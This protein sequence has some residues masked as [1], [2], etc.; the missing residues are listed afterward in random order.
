[1]A[2]PGKCPHCNGTTFC[3]GFLHR[4]T[5]LTQPAC[6][7]CLV[8]SGLPA[9]GN[10]HRVICSV[11]GGTGAFNPGGRA[12]RRSSGSRLLMLSPILLAALVASFLSVLGYYEKVKR[13]EEEQKEVERFKKEVKGP[14]GETSV[15][16]LKERVAV[17]MTEEEVKEELGPPFRIKEV[18]LG[19]DA[20]QIWRYNGADGKL[21]VSIHDGKV[22]KVFGAR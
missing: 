1:M 2:E 7:T 14:P 6:P 21:E 5:L 22:I 4:S 9:R 18:G 20:F 13:D 8:K 19:V 17:G 12:A 16:D 15:A 10:F 3:G 11:C